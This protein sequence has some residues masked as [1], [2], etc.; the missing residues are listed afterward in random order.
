MTRIL[1]EVVV[2][3]LRE[4]ADEELQRR[5]WTAAQ[6][7]EVGS[8]VEA[9]SRLLDDSG[10]G[11]ALDRGTK[12]FGEHADETLAELAHRLVRIDGTRAPAL[13]LSDPR[14]EEVRRLAASALDQV[15][16][17]QNLEE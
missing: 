4:L 13:V 14:M 10:L 7:P 6:G 17:S 15:S 1:V 2:D 3:A 16:A 12:V 9:T 5:R 8:I 11:D